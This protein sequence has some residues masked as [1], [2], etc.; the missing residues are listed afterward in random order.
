MHDAASPRAP[1]KESSLTQP[2]VQPHAD[3]NAP[4][5]RTRLLFFGYD[6]SEPSHIR[7]IR[8]FTDCGL[9]VRAATMRREGQEADGGPEVFWDNIHLGTTQHAAMG[10]RLRAVAGAIAALPRY[11]KQLAGF[12]VI[13][14]RNLDM[15]AIAAAARAMLRPA[16]PLV[17]EC[18]DIHGMMTDPGAKGRMARAFERRLL[19]RTS[20]LVVSSPAF[21]RE[22]FAPLQGWSG[23]VTVLENKLWLGPGA[24]SRPAPAEAKPR[25][26]GARVVLGWVGA[27]RCAR[28]L[29]IL[30]ETARR[31]GDAVEV[32]M[33]GIVHRHALPDFDATLAAHANLSYHGPYSYPQGLARIYADCD[34]VWSQDLW[35]WGTNSTWLL[36]NRIYEAGYYGCPSVAVLGTETGRRVAD[37]L[38]WA[39]AAPS[40]DELCA[41][42][43][44]L[45]ARQI[46]AQRRALLARPDSDFRQTCAEIRAAVEQPIAPK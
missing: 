18:L 4:T 9:D 6:S 15:L 11:R 10:Q 26:A 40:A 36:P 39:I 3:E 34:L 29:A 43:S 24:V 16:P 14:A 7:R 23:P 30:A 25:A 32:R 13:V 28:S 5:R 21:V 19:A 2:V 22:Y 31:L 37:G 33:H 45:D 17:Y 46:A 44:R 20:A 38:G 42:L 12:D 35:Q 1:H 8:A 27:L 41:L